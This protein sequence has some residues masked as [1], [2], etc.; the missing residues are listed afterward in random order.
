[1]PI[2]YGSLSHSYHLQ[3]VASFFFEFR[4][5]EGR[6]T[7]SLGHSWCVSSRPFPVFGEPGLVNDSSSSQEEDHRRIKSEKR[8]FNV[9]LGLPSS[10]LFTR[11]V[12]ISRKPLKMKELI[13]E[14]INICVLVQS[15]TFGFTLQITN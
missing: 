4:K 13:W 6:L 9:Q 11:R 14:P 15:I 2:S 12:S 7:V 1:M 3:S 5:E 8:M 10:R